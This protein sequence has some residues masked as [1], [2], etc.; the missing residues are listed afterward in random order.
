[1]WIEGMLKDKRT[2]LEGG[3]GGLSQDN[4]SLCCASRYIT[5]PLIMCW[6][7]SSSALFRYE[8]TFF[9]A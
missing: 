4:V 3:K 9:C 8:N 1:M 2:A 5:N 7:F 6:K